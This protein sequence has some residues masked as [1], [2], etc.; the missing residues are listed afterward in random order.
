MEK[1]N[2]I[3]ED[4]KRKGLLDKIPNHEIKDLL[5]IRVDDFDQRKR[6]RGYP[7]SIYY[8]DFSSR[9]AGEEKLLV[10][11]LEKINLNDPLSF[12]RVSMSPGHLILTILFGGIAV[13]SSIACTFFL[14]IG[15]FYNAYNSLAFAITA[16]FIVWVMIRY[17]NSKKNS[18]EYFEEKRKMDFNDA[19]V[20]KE[21]FPT[22]RFN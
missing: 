17:G 22:Y 10:E 4:L 18:R 11:R 14:C 1:Y 16:S 2:E 8:R 15:D 3:F 9:K 7:E 5:N 19:P 21:R 20:L 12:W 6:R 13:L